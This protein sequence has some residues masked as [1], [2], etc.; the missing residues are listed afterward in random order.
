MVWHENEGI[1]FYLISQTRLVDASSQLFSPNIVGEQI[2]S[3]VTRKSEFVEM[4]RLMKS[5]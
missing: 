3:F 1:Q 5:F 2:L 4:P